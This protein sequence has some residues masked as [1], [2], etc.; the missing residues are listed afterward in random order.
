MSALEKFLTYSKKL[1]YASYTFTAY[2][3]SPALSQV[4]RYKVKQLKRQIV[5]KKIFLHKSGFFKALFFMIILVFKKFC[6][7]KAHFDRG[8]GDVCNKKCVN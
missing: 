5:E 3:I 8:K 6:A 1:A 2:T 7:L 4:C